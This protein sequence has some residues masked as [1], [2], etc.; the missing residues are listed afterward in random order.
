[1]LPTRC[2]AHCWTVTAGGAAEGSGAAHRRTKAVPCGGTV[3]VKAP[4]KVPSSCCDHTLRTRTGPTLPKNTS[5]N[6]T[7]MAA[8]AVS[9][10]L[11]SATATLP[12]AS[13]RAHTSEVAVGVRT[14]VPGVPCGSWLIAMASLLRRMRLW[15][16]ETLVRSLPM[17]SGAAT[18]HHTAICVRASSSE[19]H[20]LPISS[21]SGSFQCPGAPTLVRTSPYVAQWAMMLDREAQLH[22]M[23]AQL[24]HRLQPNSTMAANGLAAS[25]SPR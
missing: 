11:R 14:R 3:A 9:C 5:L 19:M 8:L 17:I 4:V 25:L 13:R 6:V 24:R 16:G 7:V 20:E 12:S 22:W 21:M 15:D 18:T 23:S 10:V 1:M 2:H